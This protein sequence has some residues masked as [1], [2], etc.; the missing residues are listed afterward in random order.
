MCCLIN[1]R[2]LGFNNIFNNFLDK[3]EI[4][5][6]KWEKTL[7]SED[8]KVLTFKEN[9]LLKN[10]GKLAGNFLCKKSLAKEEIFLFSKYF[11][12]LVITYGISFNKVLDENYEK[13]SSRFIKYKKS[14]LP[15][16]DKEFLEF[17][18][19]PKNFKI[20]FVEK[21]QNVISMRWNGV[22]IG[23]PLSDNSS[24]PDGYRFHDVFHFSYAAMLHWSPTFRGLIKHKRKS[25]SK[26]E[27]EQS[28]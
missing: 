6:N 4:D 14:D 27:D 15:D 3:N 10:L 1:R 13:I 16:F 26:M 28:L 20:E 18:R 8:K 22:F 5:L 9:H 24:K 23:D 11:F 19:L 2:N 25:D 12:A 7:S 21:Q 17:E